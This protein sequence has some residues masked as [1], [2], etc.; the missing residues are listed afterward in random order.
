MRKTCLVILCFLCLS[1]RESEAQTQVE[2]TFHSAI[3]L[4]YQPLDV[5]IVIDGEL[6][7]TPFSISLTLGDHTFEFPFGI[8]L[9]GDGAH[10]YYLM[11]L[12]HGGN[13]SLLEYKPTPTIHI[14][15]DL[16]NSDLFAL[17]MPW[18]LEVK[19][20]FGDKKGEFHE[21]SIKVQ[22]EGD[23]Y[24]TPCQ[25][26]LP[27]GMPFKVEA[28]SEIKD[29]YGKQLEFHGWEFEFT[30]ETYEEYPTLIRGMDWYHILWACYDEVDNG[31]PIT[32]YL[33]VATIAVLL[34]V[35][36]VAIRRRRLL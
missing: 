16:N 28:P 3:W 29:Y 34:I 33:I 26:A 20:G 25:T 36:Y 22:I 10:D 7:R 14:T 32:E 35:L 31:T 13:K 21:I 1:V 9:D 11:Q 4:P 19:A 12:Q 5:D 27:T 8:D 6:H 18:N 17:Y 15:E 30:K 2:V 24:D 23:D